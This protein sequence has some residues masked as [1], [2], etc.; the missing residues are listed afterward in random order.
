MVPMAF[1][2]VKGRCQKCGTKGNT[3]KDGNCPRR[4]I[5]GERRARKAAA[6]RKARQNAEFQTVR[7]VAVTGTGKVS[8]SSD[9]T[10]KKTAPAPTVT[11]KEQ[12]KR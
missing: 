11:G 10:K 5:F 7:G 8:A 6:R 4:G 9:K 12:R 3:H 1:A 2:G